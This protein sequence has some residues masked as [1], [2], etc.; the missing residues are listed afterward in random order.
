M[1]K[2][3]CFIFL[4]L[5]LIVFRLSAES[6]QIIRGFWNEKARIYIN[7]TLTELDFQVEALQ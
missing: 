4:L 3:I 5:C 6:N 7:D 1:K 2:R